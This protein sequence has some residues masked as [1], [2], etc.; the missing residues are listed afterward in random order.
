MI[1]S[2][3][4]EKIGALGSIIAYLSA[5]STCLPL[6]GPASYDNLSHEL[7]RRKTLAERSEA[8]GPTSVLG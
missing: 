5:L 1:Q 7:I 6:M 4:R 8:H 2:E 3:E